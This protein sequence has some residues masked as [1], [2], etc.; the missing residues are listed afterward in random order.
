VGLNFLFADFPGKISWKK[1][2]RGHLLGIPDLKAKPA[3][4]RTQRQALIFAG[5]GDKERT[6]EALDRMTVLGPFRVS[7]ALTF[8]ELDLIRGDPRSTALRKR[9][10]LPE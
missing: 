7:R 4:S 2:N 5:L 8:P 9:V 10:A 1:L 6:L 3:L